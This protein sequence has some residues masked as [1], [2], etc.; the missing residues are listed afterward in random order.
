[1]RVRIVKPRWKIEFEGPASVWNELLR[2][3]FGG[4]EGADEPEAPAEAV[5][6]AQPTRVDVRESHAAAQ[7]PRT[8]VPPRDEGPFPSSWSSEADE[9]PRRDAHEPR[10]HP[11][12]RQPRGDHGHDGPPR[13]RHGP[14][15]VLQI[16]PSA[17]PR[18]LY[19]R[20]GALGS[21]RVEKDSVLAAVWFVGRGERDV[22]HQEVAKHLAENGGPTD[23]AVRPHLFKHV[24]RSKCLVHGEAP[25]SVRL[26][27]KGREQIRLLTGE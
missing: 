26:T 4:P 20:I 3:V 22:S 5:P 14:E 2:P 16:E 24:T 17:D 12:H 13:R 7:R 10:M 23:L 25:G 9:P 1:M 6:A 11:E 19:E 15:P 18:T 21:R 8:W 27:D